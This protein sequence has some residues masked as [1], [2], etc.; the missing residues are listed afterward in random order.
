MFVN[1]VILTQ[2]TTG[3]ATYDGKGEHFWHGS[4]IVVARVISLEKVNENKR[5]IELNVLSNLTGWC[6]PALYPKVRTI[7]Y[8][9]MITSNIATAPKSGSL[10]VVLLM[11]TRKGV[12]SLPADGIVFS[13]TK[14]AIVSISGLDDPLIDKI[15][16]TIQELRK[17]EREKLEAG[18]SAK[19]DRNQ[20]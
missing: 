2:I 3:L 7:L 1:L 15:R 12:I 11:R 5:T 8:L 10:I 6:D 14:C 19:P 16:G 18:D 20:K 4:S 13:P 9:G 17:A